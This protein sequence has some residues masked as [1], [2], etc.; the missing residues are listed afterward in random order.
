MTRFV[1]IISGLSCCLIIGLII[2]GGGG[3]EPGPLLAAESSLQIEGRAGIPLPGGGRGG[4]PLEAHDSW[5]QWWLYGHSIG[6]AAC[7]AKD[8]QVHDRGVE[9]GD[10]GRYDQAIAEFTKCVQGNPRYARAY[11]NRGTA[12]ARLG[13][14]DLAIA[15]FTKFLEIESS[16]PFACFQSF[17]QSGGS[18]YAKRPIRAGPGRLQ[19]GP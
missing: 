6:Y 19:P 4:P 12:Y 11:Y 1:R 17:P 14:P 15:D 13:Q 9:Y 10:Q 5:R 2:L 16:I 18:L 7:G 3:P 8:L